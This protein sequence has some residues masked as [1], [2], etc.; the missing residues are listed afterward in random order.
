M[1]L[2]EGV[3]IARQKPNKL[4]NFDVWNYADAHPT[5]K[6]ALGDSVIPDNVGFG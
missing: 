6:G 3:K 4:A 2:N 1:F 5:L